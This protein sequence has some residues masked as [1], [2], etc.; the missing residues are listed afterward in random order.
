M[1]CRHY[2]ASFSGL[3]R[4]QFLQYAQM[5][6]EGLGDFVTCMMSGRQRVDVREGGVVVPNYCNSTLCYQ[7]R[8]CVC[9][10]SNVT[11]SSSCTRYCKKG[12]DILRWALPVYLH[13]VTPLC[14]TKSPSP[15][16]SVFA[17]CMWSK[18][19]GGDSLGM[20]LDSI[21]ACSVAITNLFQIE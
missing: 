20:R 13:H 10:L 19:G 2:L 16:P 17:Y 14:T 7:P 3:P 15:S 6:R 4:L 1:K 18:T 8:V 21:I 12:L 9:C 5:E 11:I